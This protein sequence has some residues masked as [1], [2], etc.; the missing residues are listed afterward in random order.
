M[1]HAL[2]FKEVWDEFVEAAAPGE[3]FV[4]GAG[5][6]AGIDLD[7]EFAQLLHDVAA[8]DEVVGAPV[9]IHIMY[10][11]VE[12]VGIGKDTVVGGFYVET[13]DSTA[14]RAEPGEFVEVL[15]HDIEGLVTTPAQTGHG[16]VLTVALRAEVSVDIRNEVVE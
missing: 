3:E 2:L 6:L 13:E 4:A 1:K 7:A 16:A 11:L 8:L 14:E 12:L 10:L 5:R 9:H 15:E